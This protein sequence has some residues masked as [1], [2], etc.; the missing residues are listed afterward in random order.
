MNIACIHASLAPAL[1]A[2]GH[3]CLC[4][5]P[6]SG[7]IALAPL[8]NGFVPDL[9][10]QQ[11]TLGPRTLIADLQHFSCPKV[12]WSIDTHLNSFWQIYYARLFDLVCSTQKHWAAWLHAQGI[13]QTL[14]L[15]WFG[16]KR[17]APAW[18]TRAQALCFVGRLTAERPV[19][20]W[21]VDWLTH[22][23]P[24]QIYQDLSHAAM[25]F[26]YDNS[27]IV[28]NEAIFGEVNFRLFEAGSCGCAL[29][30]PALGHV[31]ELFTP[32]TEV[33]LFHDGAELAFW[34][35][36]LLNKPQQA[37]LL[38]LHMRQRICSEH[39]PEHRAQA[40][41]AALARS[42]RSAAHGSEAARA[43]WLTLE[44]LWSADRI[45]ITDPALERAFFS[46]PLSEDVLAALVRCTANSSRNDFLRLAV[47]VV[48]KEQYHDALSVN[49]AG[50]MSALRH[51]ELTLARA[52]TL[53]QMR[54][55]GR[56]EPESMASPVSIC[57]AWARELQRHDL[58][59]RPG[60]VF[61]PQR[62]VP[63][64]ALECLVLASEYA[65]QDKEVYRAL[66]Q[67]LART[68]GWEALRLKAL[69]YISLR[70]RDNWRLGLE[71]GMTNCQAFRVHQGLEELAVAHHTAQ[72]QGEAQR[73][74]A[75]L[76]GMDVS[77]HVRKAL[78]EY[79]PSTPKP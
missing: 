1:T 51:A 53:R 58:H 15:P 38:G 20:Q 27:Q 9:I 56:P 74:H 28:P 59:S 49:L 60:F 25:L 6:S 5:A 39:L 61:N 57:L 41:L 2:L 50:A 40:L 7:V 76:A 46:L 11:E 18:D 71:L 29:I 73:F 47:P 65:P 48:Q 34:V 78:A 54:S 72:A 24:L 22:L 52:F 31:E 19:R 36:R 55:Q 3:H 12:F 23:A 37:R 66:Q 70:E 79:F 67:A 26:C 44:Q 77:G 30:S 69:S 42:T 10:I 45:Q 35:R 43:W 21:F 4:L 32:G 17:S 33:L 75:L 62:H 8:L 14:W 63:Q 64:S 13:A 16:S 68:S